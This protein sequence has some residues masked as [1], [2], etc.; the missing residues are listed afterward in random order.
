M[1]NCFENPKRIANCGRGHCR[2]KDKAKYVLLLSQYIRNYKGKLC[3]SFLVHGL[4]KFMPIA[5]G[6]ETSMVVS[7]ALQGTLSDPKIH[8]FLVLGMIAA[9]GI[10]NYFDI[11]VSHDVA[12]RILT[13]LRSVSYEKIAMIAPAGLQGEK[14]GD[15]MSVVLEDIEILEWFYAHSVVQVFVAVLLPLIA[16]IVMGMFSVEV[17]LILFG[18]ILLITLVSVYQKKGADADG[19]K[20][21]QELGQLN[22]AMIDGI[23]GLKDILTFCWQKIYFERWFRQNDRYNGA[24]FQYSRR[25]AGEVSSVDLLLGFSSLTSTVAIIYYASVGRYSYDWMLP[26]ISLS[27]MVYVPLRETLA[28]SSGYGRIFAAAERV[29]RFLQVPSSIED[30]GTKSCEEVIRPENNVLRFEKVSFAYR[31]RESEEKHEVLKEISF[32]VHE[33]ETV[34]LVGA[35]GCG[36]S[37]CIKL[38]QRF[39]DVDGGSISVN[40]I[41]I[42]DLRLK[43]L[44]EL[45]TVV[46]QDV[47]LFNRSIEEN[48]KLA[49]NGAEEKRIRQALTDANAS[50]F[51]S[52]LKDGIHTLVGEKGMKLSGGEK[53]R[54]SIAQ[55]FL[56]SSPILVLDE[57]TANLD[58]HNENMVNEALG[59][60]KRGKLTL[61]IAHRLSTIKS[62]DRIVF[63]K[64]GVCAAIGTY[65]ELIRSSEDFRNTVGEIA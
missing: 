15:I 52:V 30:H 4:Y 58:Y 5:L 60:L 65:E 26:L 44:R 33:D 40:G 11:F 29:F 35:S 7:K 9:T 61:M 51:V 3:W 57:I 2:M 27:A 64:D 62:A 25:A 39:W 10:L 31:D 41:D 22:A 63:I 48:L 21:Q 23:Q 13:E 8:F 32:E 18:F 53:Q 16:L 14:S 43:T 37:T 19:K 47:Y 42:R 6:L 24:L 28:M 59:R 56:K 50:D 45:I 55:A 38:M 34:V 36:K 49:C 12:Y 1:T 17:S 54:I 46:P 20:V